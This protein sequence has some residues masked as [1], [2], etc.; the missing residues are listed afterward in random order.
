MNRTEK[1][2]ELRDSMKIKE[3]MTAQEFGEFVLD[4]MEMIR[5]VYY[6]NYPKGDYLNM[7]FFNDYMNVSNAMMDDE[8]KIEASR[9]NDEQC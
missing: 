3:N 9:R 7:C 4:V 8:Y 2:Q 6:T 1:F 5:E